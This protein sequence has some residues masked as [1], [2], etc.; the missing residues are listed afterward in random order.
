[1]MFMLM[2]VHRYKEAQNIL[3][4]KDLYS[5]MGDEVE[6]KILGLIG[7]GASARALARMAK[8]FG[9]RFMIVARREIESVAL[10]ELRPEFVGTP[11]ELDTIFSEADFVS[12]HLPLTSATQGIVTAEKIALMKPTASFINIA[13]GDLVDQAALYS[14]LLENRIAAIGTDVHSGGYPD[15]EHPVYQHPHFYALPHVSGTTK[16]T[17]RRRAEVCLENINRVATDTPLLH[18][19]DR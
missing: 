14:A 1:M 19:V 15:P 12:L 16:G 17:V 9:L 13:R 8:P 18:R 5:P 4:K 6:G 7:F 3:A 10:E 2:I 11:T